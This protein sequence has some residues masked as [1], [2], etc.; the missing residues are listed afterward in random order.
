MTPVILDTI[1]GIMILLSV[2]FA[3]FRGFI[4]EMIT[5]VNLAAS[6]YSAYFMGPQLEPTF[7]GWL[8]TPVKEGEEAPKILGFIPPEV[9]AVFAAY[10]AAFFVVF[11]IITMAGLY[12][13]STAKA[14]GLGPVDK[15]LGIAFGGAR[16]LLLAFL[17]YL[18]FGFFMKVDE[19]PDWAKNSVTVSVLDKTYQKA[20][21]FMKARKEGDKGVGELTDPD[22][23]SGKLKKMADDMAEKANL[24]EK[25]EKAK[26]TINNAT[27]E[28]LPDDDTKGPA[29]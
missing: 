16:G 28:I 4:K 26:E 20:D 19:Y 8:V 29:E 13:S 22:S 10:A 5:I 17:I 6:S 15:I 2:I 12:I 24:D 7:T 1:T 23:V 11:I 3:F 14:L 21:Q 25:T 18:P 9:M 27:Q